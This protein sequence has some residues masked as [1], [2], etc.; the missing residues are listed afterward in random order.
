MFRVIRRFKQLYGLF[1]VTDGHIKINTS[2]LQ[3][4][5]HASETTAITAGKYNKRFASLSYLWLWVC[6]KLFVLTE[7][8]MTFQYSTL[9]WQISGKPYRAGALSPHI[10]WAEDNRCRQPAPLWHCVTL[11]L[12]INVLMIIIII[13]SSCRFPFLPLR[14]PLISFRYKMVFVRSSTL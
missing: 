11:A 12:F 14:F 1:I 9:E 3:A 7:I 13:T 4:R 8:L 2:F 10:W 6:F 5:P